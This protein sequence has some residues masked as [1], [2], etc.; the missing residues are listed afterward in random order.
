MKAAIVEMDINK[1]YD[2]LTG[3]LQDWAEGFVQM[4]PNLLLSVLVLLLF[5]VASKL[6]QRVVYKLINKI[7]GNESLNKLFSTLAFIAVMGVGIFTSLDILKLDKAVTSLLAGAGVVGLALSFAFQNA[8]TNLMAGVMIALRR[9]FKIGDILETNGFFG[10]VVKINLRS[11][12]LETF[13][14]QEVIIPN[15]EVYEN[16]IQNYSATG[17]RRIDLKVGIS[18]G[19]D[20]KKVKKVVLETLESMP[21]LLKEKGVQLHFE[22]FGNS[23]I[24]FVV[25]FWVEYPDQPGFLEGRSEIIIAIKEAFDN[26]DITIPFPIRTL[27]F[28]I[29][30]GEKLAQN[31]Q[32]LEEFNMSN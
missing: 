2:L 16:P 10:T 24:N 29:K 8:A 12:L 28:G 15:K 11:T 27:D 23:S 13:Q 7:S 18:Y 17:S 25:R 14:G 9:P 22:E 21:F 26:N 31:I 20:L 19:D 3:K 6:V 32:V 4:L 1:M 5:Y 30:G